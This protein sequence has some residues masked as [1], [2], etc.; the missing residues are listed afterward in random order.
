MR[1]GKKH[2]SYMKTLN[3]CMAGQQALY[4][5]PT[6]E[7]AHESYRQMLEIIDVR[8]GRDDFELGERDLLHISGGTITF[9][10]PK[11]RKEQPS[12]TSRWTLSGY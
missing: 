7:V 4:V 9:W 3:A 2:Y 11:D 8:Y 12:M 5:V 1:G 10:T 6:Y